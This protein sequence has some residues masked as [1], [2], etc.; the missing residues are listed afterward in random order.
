MKKKIVSLLLALAMMLSVCMLSACGGTDEPAVEPSVEGE[1]G[2]QG[3]A[4][5]D[6]EGLVDVAYMGLTE[7]GEGMYYAGASDGSF[8]IVLF[9]DPQS[10][11]TVSFVGP[12]E[13]AN[14]NQLTVTDQ[15]NGLAL[16]FSV[17]QLEDGSWYLDLGEELGGAVVAACEVADVLT[18]MQTI[19]DGG[20]PVA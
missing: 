14:D 8:A 19:N 16:T 11:N 15:V 18:A 9:A 10:L 3:V 17:Y 5:T 20:N 4:L 6:L 7:A 12:C 13:V 2:E 1:G